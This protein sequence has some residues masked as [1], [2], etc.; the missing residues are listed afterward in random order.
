MHYHC[1]QYKQTQV[2]TA[3]RGRLV[4]MMY[5]AAM[6][7]IRA[8]QTRLHAGDVSGKG[9]YISRALAIVGELRSALNLEQ[10]GEIAANLD[11]LYEFV[12]YSLTQANLRNDPQP[13]ETAHRI[14]ATLYEGWTA[15]FRGGTAQ[16]FL[17]PEVSLPGAA[18]TVNAP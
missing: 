14:L 3:D 5:E 11:R 18:P 6:G 8:A 1:G 9:K 16:T 10:G 12:T 17:V 13:L 2:T 4:L 7:S 15:I